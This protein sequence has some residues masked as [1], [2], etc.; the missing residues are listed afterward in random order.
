MYHR[1]QRF[2]AALACSVSA[3]LGAPFANSFSS[4]FASSVPMDSSNS[5]AR[6]SRNP[7]LVVATERNRWLHRKP[8]LLDPEKGG[9]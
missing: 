5:S 2:S 8:K 7:S 9:Q 1:S 3:A 4:A 6:T